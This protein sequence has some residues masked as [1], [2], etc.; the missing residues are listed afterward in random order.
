VADLDSED[1]AVREA[2]ARDLRALGRGV[3]P[4]LRRALRSVTSAEARRHLT[5]LVEAMTYGKPDA[6]TLRQGRAVLALERI[7]SEPARQLLRQLGRG[8]PEAEQT[9]DAQAA[10][11]RLEQPPRGR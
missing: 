11:A 9:R 6:E 5:G 8:A 4:T 3:E 10:L 7:A 2:A 1:F